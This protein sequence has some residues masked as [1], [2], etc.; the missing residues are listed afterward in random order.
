MIKS[1]VE[2]HQFYWN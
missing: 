2:I 1:P